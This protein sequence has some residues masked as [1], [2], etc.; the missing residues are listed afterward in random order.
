MLSDGGEFADKLIY[1]L[2]ELDIENP[3]TDP[4]SGKK[5]IIIASLSGASD[6]L[7]FDPQSKEMFILTDDGKCK[8]GD[9]VFHVFNEGFKELDEI[10]E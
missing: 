10:E 9:F 1:K 4:A 8:A 7:V 5:Y 2:N 6:C 3:A